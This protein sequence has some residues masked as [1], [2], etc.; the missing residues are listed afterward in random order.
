MAAATYVLLFGFVGQDFNQY[1]GSL[2][3][4][5]LCLGL[6][7]SAAALRDLLRA[8]RIQSLGSIGMSKAAS[9]S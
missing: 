6:A 7:W 1:W 3:A 5:L 9:A 8:S 2:I 4:P